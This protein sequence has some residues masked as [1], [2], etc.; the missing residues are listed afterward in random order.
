M[1]IK[2]LETTVKVIHEEEVGYEVEFWDFDERRSL[3][4]SLE[5]VYG[6]HADTFLKKIERDYVKIAVLDGRIIA[7]IDNRDNRVILRDVLLPN[8]EKRLAD[9]NINYIKETYGV[10]E[11]TLDACL[12]DLIKTSHLRINPMTVTN[13]S[14]AYE[15]GL[16]LELGNDKREGTYVYCP[17][18]SPQSE[19]FLKMAGLETEDY[20][21]ALEKLMGQEVYVILCALDVIAIVNKETK[22]ICVIHT[23][24]QRSVDKGDSG[25]IKMLEEKHGIS[26]NSLDNRIMKI[27][28]NKEESK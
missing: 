13:K 14:N 8:F 1:D 19:F 3:D 11:D 5:V 10:Q 23:F 6:S 2:I 26:P 24:Y 27:L 15:D 12:D 7:L 21:A 4:Y 18:G 22:D 25:N 9:D 16:E 20:K 17:S 28:K